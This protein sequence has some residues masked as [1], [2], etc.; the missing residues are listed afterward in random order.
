MYFLAKGFHMK[1]SFLLLLSFLLL[2]CQ[3]EKVEMVK[4]KNAIFFIG[5]GMGLASLTAARIYAKGSTGRMNFERFTHTGFSKTYSTDNFTTDSAAGATALA[6]GVKSYNGAISV[7]DPKKDKEQSSRELQTILD[8][9]YE[10]GKS[11]GVITTTRVT[12]AT[13][14][15]FYAHI[16]HRDKEKEIAAQLKNSNLTFL[17]GGGRRFFK[18]ELDELKK[19]GWTYVTN[20]QDLNAINTNQ[21]NLK[22]LGLFNE[23]HLTYTFDRPKVEQIETKEPT[24]AQM[25]FWGIQTLSK[26]PKGYIL[27]V[28]AG[29]I[30]HAA[31]ENHFRRQAH[32]TMALDE[33]LQIALEKASAQTLVVVTADHETAGL[34]INGYADLSLKGDRMVNEKTD[35]TDSYVSWSTGPGAKN[36]GEGDEKLERALYFKEFANHTAVDVPILANGPGAELFSGF[37]KNSDIPKKILQSLG[38]EFNSSVNKENNH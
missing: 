33:A 7:T 11:V 23:S 28:E 29:R 38:L 35:I 13:P 12:H 2:S 36:L 17:L 24:L 26:N 14:A 21:K 19:K 34:A 25:L 32:E 27:V 18:D 22:V 6:T 37:M 15:C 3:Q 4:T 31:H 16:D 9:A 1:F 30:D 5:D 20:A 8:V 10:A